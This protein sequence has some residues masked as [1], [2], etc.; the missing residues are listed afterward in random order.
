MPLFRRRG[1]ADAGAAP[2]SSLP[3]VSP[4]HAETLEDSPPPSRGD[5]AALEQMRDE[6]DRLAHENARMRD[7][8]RRYVQ[9]T[10]RREAQRTLGMGCAGPNDRDRERR[11]R[12]DRE[13]EMETER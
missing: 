3:P 10:D 1:D 7:D 2:A 12:E 5:T 9:D 13:T 11:E 6:L 8:T 4:H